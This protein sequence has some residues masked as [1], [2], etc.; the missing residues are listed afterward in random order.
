MTSLP[1]A[2]AYELAAYA[3]NALKTGD[4]TEARRLMTEA[5]RLDGAY[6]IRAAHIGEQDQRKITPARSLAKLVIAPLLALGCEVRPSGK[7]AS[8][9]YLVRERHPWALTILLGVRK[10]G[11]GIG[12]NAGRSLGG[13]PAEWFPFGSIGLPSAQIVYS[14]QQ[15]LERACGLWRELLSRHVL[16]W[17]AGE[18]ASVVEPR[19]EPDEAR[20][21]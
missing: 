13:G 18:S 14:S 5:A 12:V 21:C 17:G 6:Q 8:G 3:G 2:R 20:D 4:V 16:P 10:F 15:E 9:S 1:T 7:W 11:H 19:D